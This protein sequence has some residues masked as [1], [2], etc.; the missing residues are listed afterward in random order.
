MARVRLYCTEICPYCERAERLLSKKGAEIDKVRI[1][2]ERGRL[3]EMLA[4][5]GGRRS[6]PQIFVGDTHVGGYEELVE[7]DFS[8]ELD[9]MLAS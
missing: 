9:T 6:V 1:D 2:K 7:L 8:G 5:T 4:L 3:K